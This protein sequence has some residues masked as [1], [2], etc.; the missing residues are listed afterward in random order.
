MA[1]DSV[2]SHFDLSQTSHHSRHTDFLGAR[3]QLW[4]SSTLVPRH[5]VRKPWRRIFGRSRKRTHLENS[6]FELDPNLDQSGVHDTLERLPSNT[7]MEDWWTMIFLFKEVIFR[8]QPIIFQGV[9]SYNDK[10]IT[11][12]SQK[13]LLDMINNSRRPLDK[14]STLEVLNVQL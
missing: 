2:S 11:I 4:D 14:T 3:A 8:V 13:Q 6:H 10:N 7:I 1:F 9:S 12:P 5:D